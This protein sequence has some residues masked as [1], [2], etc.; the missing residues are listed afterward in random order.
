MLGFG[1]PWTF[2]ISFTNFL[3]RR[4]PLIYYYTNRLFTVKPVQTEQF[5]DLNRNAKHKKVGK[6]T[7]KRKAIE[8][9][10]IWSSEFDSWS[11]PGN[12]D[13]VGSFRAAKPRGTSSDLGISQRWLF[14]EARTN[15]WRHLR[16]YFSISSPWIQFQF[17]GIQKGLFLLGHW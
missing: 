5:I 17:L 16:V 9:D 7:E 10:E 13:G 14:W 15:R 12:E 3:K 6:P 2:P 8:K 4:R 11:S 1:G